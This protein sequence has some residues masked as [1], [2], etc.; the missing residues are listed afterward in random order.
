MPH[1][2]LTR[3]ED[4]ESIDDMRRWIESGHKVPSYLIRQFEDA[5]G[6]TLFPWMLRHNP[7]D[8]S[9]TEN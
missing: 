2:K 6:E 8:H 4:I 1:R 3:A 5:F 7:W 9:E